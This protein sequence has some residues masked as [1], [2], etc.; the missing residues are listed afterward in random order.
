MTPGGAVNAT[1]TITNT[2]Q[3]PYTGISVTFTTAST[4]RRSATRGDQT[5]SSG[6]LSVGAT[7]AVWTGNVPVGG[8]V[9]ITGTI[10]VDNP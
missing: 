1:T 10:I 9:T 4:A 7:G 6:T 5:A 3:V 8:T 2:G